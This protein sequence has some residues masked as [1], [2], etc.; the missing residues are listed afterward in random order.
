MQH[1][2]SVVHDEHQDAAPGLL[3]AHATDCAEDLLRGRRGEDGARDGSGQEALAD[4]ARKGRLVAG[5]AP[6]DE[7][8]GGLGGGIAEEDGLLRGVE[9]DGGVGVCGRAQSGIDESQRLVD[10]VLGW[11]WI[12]SLAA[13]SSSLVVVNN[14]LQDMASE[15]EVFSSCR[16]SCTI[17]KA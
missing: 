8:D 4:E 7:G 3:C 6:G 13:G 5:T 15:S 17:L 14:D 11:I 1:V 16:L 2:A 9:G 12:S 10:K